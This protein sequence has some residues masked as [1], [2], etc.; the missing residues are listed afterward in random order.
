MFF[1]PAVTEFLRDLLPWAGPLFRAITELGSELFFVGL[2]LTGFWAYKKRASIITSYVLLV[3]VVSNYWLKLAIANPRPDPS[4]WYPG[5]EATNY[6]TPSAHAQNTST[7]F[8]WF[9]I[10]SKKPWVIAVSIILVVLIGLSRVYLGV[11]YLEDVLLGWSIGIVTLLVITRLE[12]PITE[13][14]SRYNSDYLYLFLFLFGAAATIV[15]TYIL[16]LPPGDNFGAL[17]GLIMGMAVGYPLE[18]KYV[19]F[20]TAPPN[21]QKWRLFLRVLIG[22]CLV[23]VA[24][25]GLSPLLPS[26]NVWAR[27]LRYFITVIVGV[28]IWP[29]IFKRVGL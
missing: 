7:L 3:A 2:I 1:D 14:L 17:G 8:G 19:N 22:F 12:R 21:E 4:Y 24:M 16:P 18:A 20:E 29:A 9:S 5:V 6:S 25:I 11:H 13:I 26:V 10:R 28:V 23:V 27:A 15:N